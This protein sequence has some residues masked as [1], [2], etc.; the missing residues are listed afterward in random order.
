MTKNYYWLFFLFVAF[1]VQ[2]QNK[3]KV[4]F[5]KFDR[6]GMK[7]SILVTDVKPFTVLGQK[8]EM[9]NMYNLHESFEELSKADS[10]KR[11][12]NAD[13][14]RSEMKIENSSNTLKIGLIHTEFEVPSKE[15][16]QKGLFSILSNKAV[17]NSNE[18][19]FDKYSNTIVAP[20]AI[21]KKGLSTNFIFDRK[22]FVNTTTNKI[23]SIKTNFD[24][25]KGFVTTAVDKEITVTY[26]SEGKKEIQFEINF[27]N[28]DKIN[29]NS[30]LTVSYSNADL[31]RLFQRAPSLITATRTPDLAIYGETDLSAGKCEYEIFTSPDGIFDKP[32]YVIDGFDPT[33]SRNTT[34]VYNLLTYV[35]AGGVTRNLGDRIRNEEGFDI[36]VVNFPTYTNAAGRII[37]GGADYIERNALSVVTVM[38]T[39]NAQKIG[40]E[41]N[42]V[43]GPSMGG[44]ISRYALRYMEQNALNHQTRLW[45]SFDSPHYGANVPIGLQHLF[46]YFAYGYGDSDGVKPLINSMLRSPAA[47]QM[48]VDHFQAH[49]AAGPETPLGDD[50]IVPSTGL[51]LTPT[52][53]PGFRDN[54]QNRM[55][56]MGFPQATRNVSMINGS[57]SLGKFKDKTNND[58]NT[59]FD[60][61]G[62]ASSQAN[63]DT[64]DVFAFI[65]TRALTF[66]EFMPNANIQETI[67]DVDIQAKIFF[68]IT[69]D[70]FLATAKQSAGSNGVDSSPGGLFDMGGLADS[71]PPGDPVLTNFLGAMKADKFSFIP[72]VS[73]MALNVG[74][75]INNNQPNY[76]FNI[77]LGTK[78]YPWDG[79]TTATSNTTPFKNWYMPPT[80][81]NHVTITQGNVDFAWCE[82]VKPDVDFANTGTDTFA[83]CQGT[84]VSFT[85]SNNVHGCNAITYTA[86][87]QPAGSSVSFSP[88]TITADGNVTATINNLPVGTHTITITP[89]GYPT[90]A[91]TVTVTI[92]PANP[93]LT[94][95][96]QYKINSGSF[97]T[98][99]SVT[100][101]QGENLELQIPSNL[102]TGTIEWFN[103]TG[104]SKGST[105]PVITNIQDGST[106][107]GTW[108]AKVTFVNDCTK[109]AASNIPFTVNVDTSLSADTNEFLDL[110][111]YPNPS[112]DRIAITS[113]IDLSDVKMQII[114]L[115][116][117]IISN[118]KAIIL[119]SNTIQVDI[120]ELAQ[121]P[122]L[123]RIENQK[124]KSIKTIIK[125]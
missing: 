92:N 115:R 112:N 103:P 68:W 38:E 123:L 118:A 80:N 70:S 54:F 36:V 46:N 76:Y 15:A 89:T 86:L 95:A 79:T 64:G 117:R 16:Y 114:D 106:N 59:G 4:D 66:C 69:Q 82:I 2:S 32:I 98:G 51:P 72:A 25:G 7:T 20:L 85:F 67:V 31:A 124:F 24:D 9:Y 58:I 17:R 81:E 40:T 91:K 22:M 57:G 37:D 23:T 97:T 62:T 100:V 47:K 14:I 125:Q 26:S 5:S 119:N 75:N 73:G 45:V 18:Y 56:T 78:D 63:I 1:G 8:K 99:S 113:S 29:R 30:V 116:G 94:G 52:G 121:G 39:L 65:N 49:I 21:R 43:I 87:G 13:L 93:N 88:A 84:S 50:P 83:T 19:I 48:L 107:E 12:L 74:G 55:N 120:S 35:D 11:F 111:I 108:N 71:L 110:I 6:T 60:F 104:A 44:L 109:M 10:K 27:E 105:N 33:D 90:K 53:Y 34:A 61:I 28:G 101:S 3:K 102:Y 122:Y 42:V 96:T 41:Q 77:N